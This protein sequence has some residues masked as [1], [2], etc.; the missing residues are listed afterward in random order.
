MGRNTSEL[1]A[2][3][4]KASMQAL[5]EADGS[6]PSR[7]VIKRAKE[8]ANPTGDECMIYSS[9]LPKWKAVLHFQSIGLVK[10]GWIQKRKGVWHLTP[11]GEKVA[12]WPTETLWRTMNERYKEWKA[13][14]PDK[15][16][17]DVVTPVG[18]ET[19]TED[20][21]GSHQGISTEEVESL[22]TQGIE[23]AIRALTPYEFQDLVAALFRGMGYYTPFV[24]PKGKDGGVDVIA[25]KDPLGTE[26]P[27]I[28]CQVK[29]RPD[30]AAG[31][32]DVQR[33]MGALQV[34]KN[35]GLFVTSGRFSA[36]AVH[37][38]RTSHVHIELVD[39][40]RFIDL[41]I[42]HYDSLD[43]DDRAL[44][45]LRTIHVLSE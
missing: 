5:V 20:G 29:H 36:D 34:G 18:D 25:Y 16:P 40:S 23:K 44:L 27:A 35:V 13:Q 38:A 30:A 4:L 39:M 31:I 22:A 42:E 2:D 3:L 21:N 14:Q 7:E 17:D 37:A 43:E 6:S 33:L 10:A 1:A 12:K 15:E 11:E 8:I 19:A 45:R 26:A 24:A 32:A 28:L 41:W 9:G